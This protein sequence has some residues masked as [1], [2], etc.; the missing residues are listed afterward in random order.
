VLFHEVKGSSIYHD[1]NAYGTEPP[2]FD[3]PDVEGGSCWVISSGWVKRRWCEAECGSERERLQVIYDR[4]IEQVRKNREHRAA[5]EQRYEQ[6][7]AL[8]ES[9][10][11][12]FSERRYAKDRVEFLFN[13]PSLARL[14]EFVALIDRY[15][16]PPGQEFVV[17]F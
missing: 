14:Q 11:L 12:P 4:Y 2:A 7:M 9:L 17:D 10:G 6:G 8:L 15:H 13:E 5:I 16:T 1:I 3:A